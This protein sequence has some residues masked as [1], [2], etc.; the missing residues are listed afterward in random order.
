MKAIE[1]GI[2]VRWG[3]HLRTLGGNSPEVESL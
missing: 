3:G 1:K 2:Y